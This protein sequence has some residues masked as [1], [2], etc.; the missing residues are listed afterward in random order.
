[1]SIF[2]TIR[3]LFGIEVT[4]T[5][6]TII[7]TGFNAT[8]MANF[9][10]R[11]WKTSVIEKHMFKS[12][13]S[14]KMEFYKFFLIDV[15][16]IFETLVNSPKKSHY[17]PIRTIRDIVEKLK[18]QTFYKDVISENPVLDRLDMKKLDRFNYPP[19]SF[20]QEWL[21]YYNHT[22]T[23]YRLRGALLNGTP[24]S[25]KALDLDTKVKIP[26]GWRKI[27]Y[28]KEGDIILTPKG[29][30]T[31]VTG[32]YDHVDRPTYKLIFEDGRSCICDIDH[33]WN[34]V[35]QKGKHTTLPFSELLERFKQGEHLHI[36]LV[37]K[38]F[39]DVTREINQ[40]LLREDVYNDLDNFGLDTYLRDEETAKQLQR[41]YWSK[42]DVSHLEKT[43]DGWIVSTVYGFHCQGLW[44]KSIQ[45]AGT[46]NTRCIKI[47]DPDELFVI[48]DYIVTHNTYI[49]LV[50]A[51][52]AG[53]DRIIVV[54][55]KN[56]LQR[57]W[58]DDM[59][60]HFKQPLKYWN[61]AMSDEPKPDTQLFIY[62]YEAIEKAKVHHQ[63][64]F[65][66]FKYAMVLD[67]SHNLN[68]IKSIRTQAWLDLVRM[69][70][71]ENVIHA[72]GTP[73][74]AMGSELIPLLRAID[75]SFTPEAE[76]AFRKI[77]G[78]SAQKGLD[79][80]KHRLG[81]MSFVITKERLELDKPEMITQ[82]V[83][84]P[85]GKQFTLTAIREQMNVFIA[86]RV[87]YYKDREKEDIA[88]WQ[89]CL[90]IHERSLG[91]RDQ[92]A[93][94]RYLD[95]VRTIQKSGGD[96][97]FLPDEVAYCKQYEKNKIEPSLPNMTYVKR[98]REVAPIIKYLTLKIQGECLGRVVGK[99]RVDAHVA[100][101]Q[102]IP[103]REICQS[104][105]K[106]TVVFT[107]FVEVL[108]TA[109]KACKDQDL[110]PLL[111]YGK[112]N[113]DLN[114]IVSSFDKNP[115]VNPLIATYNS[116]STAVPLTMADTMILINSPYRTY[117]LEQAISRIHRLGQDSKTRIYQLF[118]DTGNE[119]NI[120]ERS[121]DIMRWSQ[122]QVEAITGVKS[123]YEIKEGDTETS[124]GVEG[125]DELNTLLYSVEDFKLQSI[126]PLTAKP[127]RS[128]W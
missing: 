17:L 61:S 49:S 77:F 59:L 35:D 58:V 126:V 38:D 6:Q 42:G 25:G 15:I 91:F 50:T 116:L 113:K 122:E 94:K 60:K 115:D 27:R 78:N 41:L 10:S 62:H 32:I 80:I 117:I 99:A 33:L 86:E 127:S 95:C 64:S 73:F 83:K 2:G 76:N 104:T 68:D 85:N 11:F 121:L 48:E 81:L 108:E 120:S 51:T 69:S 55:P 16:Y 23:R 112:T 90:E 30:E 88:T 3:N 96:I 18:T 46:R 70:G 22:P 14:S 106:K 66:K 109:M 57:V 21:D 93:Y 128:S 28:L 20:Q 107:S 54:C 7:I 111:V 53:V 110:N 4:E 36:P 45:V 47:D 65:G 98:F 124:I 31:K 43:K 29:T 56:A 71:S 52:L 84:I 82:G 79:I 19:K 34:I 92:A 100:M 89:E 118:L 40:I 13:T 105:L 39:E 74:K 26:G 37:V 1:M 72:S 101:C 75:P 123:P 103:F 102:Y 8:D 67:E 87:K 125:L 119:K 97:R 44:L 9:I 5:E 63:A 24:G 12:L 114:V